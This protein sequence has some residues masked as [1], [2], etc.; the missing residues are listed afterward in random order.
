MLPGAAWD[1][2]GPPRRTGTGLASISA[3]GGQP[4]RELRLKPA[5]LCEPEPEPD[6]P[7]LDVV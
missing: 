4:R 2:E 5:A 7:G 6:K 1:D 3:D